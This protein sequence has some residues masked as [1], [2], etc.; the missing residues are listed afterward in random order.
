M[1]PF[2][3]IRDFPDLKIISEENRLAILRLLMDRSYTLSQLGERLGASAARVRHH[4]KILEHHGLV[5]LTKTRRVRGFVEKYYRASA[6]AFFVHSAILP[7]MSQEGSIFIVGS[8]DPA[9]EILVQQ[10]NNLPGT[11]RQLVSIP[12]GSLEGLLALRRGFCHVTGC[13]LFDPV[14]REYNTSY[15]RHLFPGQPMHVITLAQRHQGLLVSSGNPLA[16]KSLDDLLRDDLVFV[17]RMEGSGT[18]LWLDQKINELGIQRSGIRGYT[19]GVATHSAVAEMILYRKADWGLGVMAAARKFNLDFI[20]LFVERFDLVLP[21][22][23]YLS[24]CTQLLGHVQTRQF[25]N[26]IHALGGYDPQQTGVEVC[27]SP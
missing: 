24:C 12:V 21:D 17:N 7:E 9:L 4:L 20:P 14:G 23:E 11:E 16:I 18:R 13:H 6:R 1:N 3:T 10:V 25:R 8:H 15:V 26:A 19:N 27:L 5:Q 22:A 2:Q